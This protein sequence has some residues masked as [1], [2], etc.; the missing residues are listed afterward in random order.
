M[1]MP[2]PTVPTTSP[3]GFAEDLAPLL[4]D[5]R[6]LAEDTQRS[7]PIDSPCVLPRATPNWSAVKSVEL[8]E[9]LTEL[10]VTWL[11][12]DGEGGTLGEVTGSR[13]L[14]HVPQLS[15]PRQVNLNPASAVLGGWTG[16]TRYRR[17]T[18]TA[19]PAKGPGANSA[20]T[21]RGRAQRNRADRIHPRRHGR[22]CV[23]VAGTELVTPGKAIRIRNTLPNP[24][25]DDVSVGSTD[26]R[27]SIAARSVDVRIRG[28]G[29]RRRDSG[30]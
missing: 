16:R 26:V 30:A 22:L 6:S 27:G 18:F 24:T 3:A 13:E 29:E 10:N 11:A 28:A 23:D 4:D 17:F 14:S 21:E 1:P 20:A 7:D 8:A 25:R 5:L 2:A 15:G 9:R 19:S 12:V